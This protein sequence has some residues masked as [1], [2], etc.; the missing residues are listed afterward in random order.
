MGGS[1]LRMFEP[2]ASLRRPR[3]GRAPQGARSV[4]KGLGQQGSFSLPTFFVDTKKVGAPPGAHPGTTRKKQY[5]ANESKLS[6]ANK[7]RSN[8]S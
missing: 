2:K 4:A 7:N 6:N 3:P 8:P 5:Q 1:G